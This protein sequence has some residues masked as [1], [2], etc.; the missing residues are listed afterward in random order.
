MVDF[1][2]AAALTPVGSQGRTGSGP[3]GKAGE[4]ADAIERRLMLGGYRFGEALS[5]TQLAKQFGASRQP[6]SMAISHLRSIGYVDIM[7]QVGCR[8]V[9]PAPAEISDFFV[10]VGR[11]EGAVAGFAALRHVD[12]EALALVRIAGRETPGRLETADGRAAY[13]RNV[14]DFHDQVWKMARS[15]LLEGRIAQLRKLSIFYLW[16]GAAQLA[17]LAAQQLNRERAAISVA[18]AGR[19][20]G[21]AE[22][23]ME[24]HIANKPVVNGIAPSRATSVDNTFRRGRIDDE[25]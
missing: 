14:N 2:S 17:P 12:D 11:M 25:S 7:P 1:E 9:S 13:I 6:V 5:I 21:G 4:I 3:S 18:I 24:A 16:Q 15:P 10:A 23:L 8:V 22:R 19:D 20:A